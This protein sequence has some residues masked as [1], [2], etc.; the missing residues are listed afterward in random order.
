MNQLANK[1]SKLNIR[2]IV[3]I[4]FLVSFLY[5]LPYFPWKSL[6]YT[7]EQDA[8]FHLAR[9][10]ELFQQV[11]NGPAYTYLSM[12]TFG[13]IGYG[14]NYFYPFLMLFVAVPFRF[15]F[16]NPFISWY[17]LIFIISLATFLIAYYSMWRFSKDKIRSLL[18]S[19]IYVFSGFR[20]ADFFGRSALGEAIAFAF[21]PLVFLG[22]YYL[23]FN[24]Y[25]KWYILTIGMTLLVYTHLLSVLMS[26]MILFLFFLAGMIFS[27]DRISRIMAAIKA[28]IATLCLSL[29]F[30]VPFIDQYLWLQPQGANQPMLAEKVN[31]LKMMLLNS[32]TDNIVAT[33]WTMNI[34]L[35]MLILTFISLFF[36]LRVTLSGKIALFFGLSFTILSTSLVPWHLVQE[37]PIALIQFPWRFLAFAMFFL[38]IFCSESLSLL[39]RKFRNREYCLL[40]LAMFVVG[41]HAVGAV[42][43]RQYNFENT[44]SPEYYSLEGAEYEKIISTRKNYDYMKKVSHENKKSIAGHQVFL[45]NKK[46]DA[47]QVIKHN[48]ISYQLDLPEKTTVDLPLIAYKHEVIKVNDEEV[49]W[50]VSDRGTLAFEAPAGKQKVQVTAPIPAF[51]KGAWL[52]SAI[53]AGVLVIFIKRKR[54]GE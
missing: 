45:N 50:Q 19:F 10:E 38:A 42:R 23:F 9:I 11:K 36:F 17:I 8:R 43:M 15:L 34:G 14:V 3:L 48:T 46:S 47:T 18:F 31:S 32:A 4:G 37:T 53:S 54:M 29:G 2:N 24:N 27:G 35:I 21:F 13:E 7:T 5:L 28:V 26:S 25:R 6:A 49:D 33:S 40:L 1:K 16:S 51:Y 12:H 22:G 39:L 52:A 41:I 20:T 30:F 44:H